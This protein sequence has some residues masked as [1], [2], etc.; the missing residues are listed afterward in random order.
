MKHKGTSYITEGPI[1]Y[2][3]HTEGLEINC[4]QQLM[5]LADMSCS[6]ITEISY[7]YSGVP[8]QK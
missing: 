5:H 7:L 3:G 8:E 2:T 1:L 6:S 4:S